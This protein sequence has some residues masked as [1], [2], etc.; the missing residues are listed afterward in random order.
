MN[1]IASAPSEKSPEHAGELPQGVGRPA[2]P[3]RSFPK[4][5]VDIFV[6]D[7]GERGVDSL[8]ALVFLLLDRLLD[9]LEDLLEVLVGLADTQAD[10][11][12]RRTLVEDHHEDDALAHDR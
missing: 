6:R 9:H 3:A 7:L 10:Q 8:R 12:E 1:V 5:T 11:A 2:G 4:Q